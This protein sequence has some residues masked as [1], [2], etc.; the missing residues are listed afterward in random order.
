MSLSQT[1]I[2]WGTK[3]GYCSCCFPYK[4]QWENMPYSIE[5][6]SLLGSKQETLCSYQ[7]DYCH[8][9][10]LSR[11][12][13]TQLQLIL[14]RQS[15]TSLVRH[16]YH[17]WVQ[18]NNSILCGK[19]FFIIIGFKVDNPMI[20]GQNFIVIIGFQVGIYALPWRDSFG[21]F[22]SCSC[23]DLVITGFQVDG[24]TFSW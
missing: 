6:L 12:L 23:L 5:I 10:V 15:Y 14:D 4:T 21:K 8:H 11:Q 20:F 16:L 18:V 3:E 13:Y 24:L 17:L 9:Q 19:D 7:P 1:Y 22:S 2:L